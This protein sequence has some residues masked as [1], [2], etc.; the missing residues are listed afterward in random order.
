[1]VS[2]PSNKKNIKYLLCVIDILTKYAWFKHLKDKKYKTVI[3]AFI[4]TVNESTRKPNRLWVDHGRN[5]YK[6]LMEE[7]LNNIDILM[8]S[9]H[10]EDKSVIDARFLKTFKSKIYKKLTANDRKSYLPYLN[11]LVDQY[12]NTYHRSIKKNPINA[13]NSASSNPILIN[14]SQILTLINLN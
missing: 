12:N 1:M 8:Y 2:L 13:D 6:K 3:N 5:F 10:K 4:E 14:P 9:T 7:W 11:K